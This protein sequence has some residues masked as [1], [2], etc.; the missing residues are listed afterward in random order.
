MK[1]WLWA[2]LDAV[3]LGAPPAGQEGDAPGSAETDAY[4]LAGLTWTYRLGVPLAL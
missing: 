4:A 1:R 2:V 3:A